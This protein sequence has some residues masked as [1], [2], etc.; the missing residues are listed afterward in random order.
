[1]VIGFAARIERWNR[2]SGIEPYIY[3]SMGT[4]SKVSLCLAKETAI[5]KSDYFVSFVP[6]GTHNY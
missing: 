5:G 4:L 2:E 3:E 1:V 6:L